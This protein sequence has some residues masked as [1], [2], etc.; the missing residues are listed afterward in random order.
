MYNKGL[1]ILLVNMYTE[2]KKK[3]KTTFCTTN[4]I[5]IV[6]KIFFISQLK[7]I[8]FLFFFC[9]STLRGVLSFEKNNSHSRLHS[10]SF[11]LFF[12]KP[13][14]PNIRICFKRKITVKIAKTKLLLKR[15]ITGPEEKN[16][17]KITFWCF[18][19]SFVVLKIRIFLSFLKNSLLPHSYLS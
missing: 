17:R 10:C 2:P 8:I 11:V 13:H 16:H 5:T 18:F 1:P 7:I 12:K 4:E 3:D 6:P 14:Y 9:L 15:T 19:F